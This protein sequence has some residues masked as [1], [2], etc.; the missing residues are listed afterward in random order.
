MQPHKVTFTDTAL[1]ANVQYFYKVLAKNE[2]AAP[3]S[4]TPPAPLP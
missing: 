3:Y 1:F 2:A 4:A